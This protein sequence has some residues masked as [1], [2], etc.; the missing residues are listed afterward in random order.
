[1]PKG[2]WIMRQKK[3]KKAEKKMYIGEKLCIV[4][5]VFPRDK[6]MCTLLELVTK[7]FLKSAFKPT[8]LQHSDSFS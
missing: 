7:E 6:Y 5:T 1:M 4:Y 2:F 8:L 3:K